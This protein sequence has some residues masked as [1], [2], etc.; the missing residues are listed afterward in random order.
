MSYAEQFLGI[1]YRWWNPSVSCCENTG[2]FWASEGPE[3]PIG[4]VQKGQ[5]NCAGLLNLI[6]RKFGLEIPGAKEKFFYAGGTRCWWL[7]FERK[8]LLQPFDPLVEYPKGTLLLRDYKSEDDQGHIA[9]V[10]DRTRVLHSW[11]DNGVA[12]EETAPNYYE[13]VVVG[14]VEN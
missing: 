1:P 11:P 3:V 13:A 2:P 5:M 4:E 9:F 14:F 12:I 7:Y 8:G 6:C 10:Y